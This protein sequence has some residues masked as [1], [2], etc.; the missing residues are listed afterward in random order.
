MDSKAVNI[1][2]VIVIVV[3]IVVIIQQMSK[4]E[5]TTP[6]VET[7]A[8]EDWLFYVESKDIYDTDNVKITHCPTD[9]N[10]FTVIMESTSTVTAFTN[11]PSHKSVRVGNLDQLSSIFNADTKNP[12]VFKEGQEQLDF[13][14]PKTAFIKE[15]PNCTLSFTRVTG[16]MV[17]HSHTI[18]EM[19]DI[20]SDVE[21]KVQMTFRVLEGE[22]RPESGQYEHMAMTIDDF[23]TWLA[24]IGAGI[25]VVATAGLAAPAAA[26]A[27]GVATATLTQAAS[28]GA[29]VGAVGGF[30]TAVKN[31]E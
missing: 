16:T 6:E 8:E 29:F 9:A 15:K 22:D 12:L 28:I 25:V 1:G 13:T 3:L 27:V 2:T 4:S 5:K 31:N 23:W 11:I 30:G 17:T 7:K 18:A 20:K 24:I 10:K 26:A 21:D 14:S 19:E